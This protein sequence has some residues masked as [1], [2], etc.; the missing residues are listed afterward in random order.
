MSNSA[1]QLDKG[2]MR[3]H[4][5]K[6]EKKENKKQHKRKLRRQSKNIDLP[7]PQHNRYNG[8]AV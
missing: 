8:W 4:L 6:G 2:V 1:Q 5:T 7:N 3:K